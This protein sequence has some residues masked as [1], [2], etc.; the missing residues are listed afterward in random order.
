MPDTK[1]KVT[2]PE[3][4]LTLGEKLAGQLLD[5][6]VREFITEHR[7]RGGSYDHIAHELYYLTDRVVDVTAQT[8]RLWDERSNA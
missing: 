8:V 5:Q 2:K 1:K 6:P 4:K 7:A 3:K